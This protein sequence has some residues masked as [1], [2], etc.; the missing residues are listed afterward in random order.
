M[1]VLGV[2]RRN[3]LYA[4]LTKLEFWLEKVAFLGHGLSKKFW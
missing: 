4:K 1:E 2:V 3:E